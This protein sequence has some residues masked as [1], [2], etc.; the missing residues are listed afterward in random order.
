MT[1]TTAISTEINNN[2]MLNLKKSVGESQHFFYT[3]KLEERV[4]KEE[5]GS[6]R[7]SDEKRR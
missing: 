1:A 4:K 3:K 2:K 7:K 6:K 5:K